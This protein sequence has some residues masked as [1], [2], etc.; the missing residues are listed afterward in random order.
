MGLIRLPALLRH[1]YLHIF[2]ADLSAVRIFV[3]R[4]YSDKTM[5]TDKKAAEL[6]LGHF[7]RRGTAGAQSFPAG[8]RAPGWPGLAP[9]L[10]DNCFCKAIAVSQMLIFHFKCY[11]ILYFA[12]CQL[13]C[14]AFML[15]LL[16]DVSS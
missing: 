5:I 6:I 15:C 3:Y 12:V 11:S 14:R 4:Q 9:P 1:S 13:L 8:A 16:S 7:V 10:R 2:V